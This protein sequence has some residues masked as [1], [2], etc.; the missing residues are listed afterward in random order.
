MHRYPPCSPTTRT[1]ERFQY[2]TL[3][4]GRTQADHATTK[5]GGSFQHVFVWSGDSESAV[6]TWSGEKATT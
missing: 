6:Q 5:K 3:I 1:H 4:F 2:V